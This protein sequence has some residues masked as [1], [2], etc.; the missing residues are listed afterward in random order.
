MILHHFPRPC[1]PAGWPNLVIHARGS[2]IEYA[3]HEA[4]LSIKCVLQGQEVHEVRRIPYVVDKETYL[5]LNHGQRYASRI[6]SDQE[7]ET[8][9]IFFSREFAEQ[10]LRSF[11]APPGV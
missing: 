4:P 7:V 6:G 3:E 9:S 11:V 8:L 10:T 2:G 1:P 5:L